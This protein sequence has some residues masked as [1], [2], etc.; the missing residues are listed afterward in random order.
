MIAWL[1]AAALIAAQERVKPSFPSQVDVVTVD[2]VVLD[3]KG[4][5]V[6]KLQASDFVVSED[7]RPQKLVQFEA[8]ALAE[9][10]PT[11]PSTARSRVASNES[12]DGRSLV[13]VF[14]NANMTKLNVD[15]VKDAVSGFLATG[16]GPGDQLTVLSTGGGA[17]WTRMPQGAADVSGFLRR[18]KGL[19]V[20][21]TSSAYI[22]D[23]EAMRI[24]LYR[25]PRIGAQVQRRFYEQGAIPDS[26]P[27]RAAS[28][29][30]IG[31]GHSLVRAK[32]AEVYQN[33]LGRLSA[34]LGALQRAM[35]S[36][37]GVRSRK[38]LLLLSEG[39]VFD[40]AIAGFR[41]LSRA[42]LRSNVVLYFVDTRRLPGFSFGSAEQARA[43]LEQD[44]AESTSNERMDADGARS[45]AADSGGFTIT[46]TDL[47]AGMRRI[48]RA[49][50]AYYLLGYQPSN[51]SRDG[52]FRRIKVELTGGRD[53]DLR[54]RKGYYAPGGESPRAE[55][56]GLAPEIRA[57]LD[58]P[59]D[60]A[61]IPLR[62][63]SYVLRPASAGRSTVL[64]AAEVDPRAL[65]LRS[66]GARVEG[67]LETTFLVAARD[68]GETFHQERR[69]DLSPAARPEEPSREDRL[70][71]AARLRAAGRQLPGPA[72]RQGCGQRQD[73]LRASPV[74]GLRSERVPLLD[75]DPDRRA[76]ARRARLER[77]PAGS[78]RAA[79]LRGRRA[80]LLRVRGVRLTHGVG[81]L[82][83][84]S[85]G[86]L[87]AGATRGRS[88]GAGSAGRDLADDPDLAAGRGH[89][90]LRDRAQREG[91]SLGTSAGS[92]RPVH[93][94]GPLTSRQR[95][96]RRCSRSS[97][98]FGL[99]LKPAF[100]ASFS[101]AFDSSN[102]PV[103]M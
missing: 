74:R 15:R 14:D 90:R 11:A 20:H 93:G 103:S 30:G 57:P 49:S 56:K 23:Y 48:A 69:V 77:A 66:A 36:L 59:F 94:R 98:N 12:R 9:S 42:A 87:A 89:G 96:L 50:R 55:V 99:T 1:A 51:A 88:A 67:A 70:P 97:L 95:P 65:A 3:K 27:T 44:L 52:K 17:W 53:H 101:S 63:A 54:A 82:R 6:E 84:A 32:A 68:S 60:D 4:E 46:P 31:G 71:F 43:V 45:L 10:A 64:L 5:P 35:E 85:R 38:S 25:D 80:R 62:L 92:P 7:G 39:F 13:L 76:A 86:R 26:L 22:S 58:S 28:Q 21:D 47:A 75:A 102:R 72:A 61:G 33:A 73:R 37:A 79:A 81:G 83:G 29:L 40:P 41:E 19:R 24:H 100:S 8:V 18:L 91:R 2:V 34:T 16:L 78:D